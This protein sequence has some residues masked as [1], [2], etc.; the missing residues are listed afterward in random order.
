MKVELPRADTGGL[1]AD[2]EGAVAGRCGER[3]DEQA[4]F[5]EQASF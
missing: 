2:R 3:G 1:A 5:E 4:S